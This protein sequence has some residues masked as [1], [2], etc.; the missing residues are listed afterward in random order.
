VTEQPDKPF[1]QN[2]KTLDDLIKEALK[3]PLF[4]RAE[5]PHP[6]DGLD[7]WSEFLKGE[8]PASGGGPV[9]LP[10]DARQGMAQMFA[11]FQGFKQVGFTEAQAFALVKDPYVE[12]TLL[13]A[14][15]HLDG[16]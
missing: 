13:Q 9:E 2:K 12:V 11:Q 1:D 15:R 3:K 10:G 7:W 5:E 16:S 8:S 14:K 4:K 6:L